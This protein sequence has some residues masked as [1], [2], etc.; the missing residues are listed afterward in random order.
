MRPHP[1]QPSA[2]AWL[3]FPGVQYDGV[4]GTDKHLV[5]EIA[6]DRRVIWV[7]PPLSWRDPRSREARRRPIGVEEQGI[8]RVRTVAPPGV[9][10]PVLREVARHLTMRQARRAARIWGPVGV[11]IVST[12]EQVLPRGGRGGVRLYYETDD[13]VAGASLLGHSVRHLTRN[14]RRNVGR[15]DAVL[16]VTSEIVRATGAGAKGHVLPNGCHPDAFASPPQ[17]PPLR[18][19]LPVPVAGVVGQLNERLDLGLLEAVVNSGVS[20]L[21]VGP[22]YEQEEEARAGLDRLIARDNVQWIDRLPYERMPAVLAELTVGLTPYTDSD[23]NRG[24]FP[25]KTLDYLAAGLPVVSSDLPSARSLG[26]P[27]V[28]LARDAAAFAR[29]TDELLARPSRDQ[30]VARRRAFA[31][32]HSWA[33]RARDLLGIADR[34]RTLPLTSQV[35]AFG[36][37]ASTEPVGEWHVPS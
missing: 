26:S 12:P 15:S 22:R 27:D 16:G 37:D 31:A 9:S 11:T 4:T 34:A 32:G 14:R 36:P 13:F 21:L 10:R 30:D 8:V 17:G 33:A 18:I 25:L 2:P 20:L 28:A 7:D 3:W 29:L 35:G 19:E 6:R 23:F 24:S 5:S 1:Q